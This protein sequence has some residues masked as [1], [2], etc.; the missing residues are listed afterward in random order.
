[1]S[2]EILSFL[3]AS[4][5]IAALVSSITAYLIKKY[6]YRSEYFKLVLNK[7]LEAYQ[8]LEELLIHFRITANDESDHQFYYSLIFDKRK[9]LENFITK[10]SLL[11]FESIWFSNEVI[12]SLDKL[13]Q[14]FMIIDQAY[15]GKSDALLI[16]EGKK[17]YKEFA[18]LKKDLEVTIIRDLEN[19]ADVRK[20]F[21]NKKNTDRSTLIF[22]GKSF[23]EPAK[24]KGF[25]SFREES[26]GN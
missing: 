3:F 25:W 19:L 14:I 5:V 7:R 12:I 1:M 16:A 15:K 2:V 24:K 11:R 9:Y 18:K 21:R 13:G 8:K 4:S 6:E 10:L 23:I 20:H 17:R 26:N 22:D